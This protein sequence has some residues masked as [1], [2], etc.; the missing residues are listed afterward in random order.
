MSERTQFGKGSS[1]SNKALNCAVIDKIWSIVNYYNN[2]FEVM[3]KGISQ[4]ASLKAKKNPHITENDDY[5]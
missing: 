5:T 2:K 1:C 3:K 4:D